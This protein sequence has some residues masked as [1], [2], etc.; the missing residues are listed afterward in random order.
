MEATRD[1]QP[2]G[3]GWRAVTAIVIGCTL[4][5]SGPLLLYLLLLWIMRPGW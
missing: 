4:I 3:P 1:H 5:V 2:R